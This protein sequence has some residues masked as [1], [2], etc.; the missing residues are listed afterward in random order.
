MGAGLLLLMLL[1]P[2]L[3]T[4]ESLGG[5]GV[6]P[7]Y[8]G[9][10]VLQLPLLGGQDISVLGAVL[11]QRHLSRGVYLVVGL[12]LLLRLRLLGATLTFPSRVPVLGAT[13][14]APVLIGRGRGGRGGRR[15]GEAHQ[16]G[17][18]ALRRRHGDHAHHGVRLVTFLRDFGLA[19]S[20]LARSLDGDTRSQT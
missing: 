3:L 17:Q 11:A 18:R 7:L 9:L 6:V 13:G 19:F 5:V 2:L 8:A 12:R 1:L 15:G 10:H 20:R 14:R 4:N 16:A